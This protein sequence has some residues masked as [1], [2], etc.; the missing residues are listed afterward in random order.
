MATAVHGDYYGEQLSSLSH[1]SLRKLA[2]LLR[3]NITD[4]QASRVLPKEVLAAHKAT[5]ENH[6]FFP[7]DLA[8][9]RG[10]TLKRVVSFTP[11]TTEKFAPL[12][13]YHRGLDSF[14]IGNIFAL[15]RHTVTELT[16]GVRSF[17]RYVNRM[18][19]MREEW[20]DVLGHTERVVGI[21]TLWDGIRNIRT[22]GRG[23]G[24]DAGFHFKEVESGC[25]ACVL[26]VVGGR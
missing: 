6:D 24:L 14:L 15:L 18:E 1:D 10:D 2:L 22:W 13:S 25:P 11:A 23:I 3:A 7:K 8:R 5:I 9:R 17:C 20:K 16:Q 19:G 21:S 12:C 26:S 4:Y